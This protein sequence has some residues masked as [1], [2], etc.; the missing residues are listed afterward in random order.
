MSSEIKNTLFR[1]VTMRAPEL[2]TENELN[3]GYVIQEK[4][5]QGVFN[6]SGINIT[7]LNAFKP[8]ALNLDEVKK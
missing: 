3:P 5:H 2:K 7:S 4:R 1:F 6:T 8:S